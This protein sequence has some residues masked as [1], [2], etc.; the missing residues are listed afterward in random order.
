MVSYRTANNV[1][2]EIAI[3][4]IA[5]WASS[6]YSMSLNSCRRAPRCSGYS[7]QRACGTVCQPSPPNERRG[8]VSIFTST[9]ELPWRRQTQLQD[10][11]PDNEAFPLPH[12][13]CKR[14]LVISEHRSVLPTVTRLSIWQYGVLLRSTTRITGDV[15]ERARD[16]SKDQMHI[17][18]DA[19][20]SSSASLRLIDF[21]ESSLD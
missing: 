17:W 15:S 20:S 4:V 6:K 21:E 3:E 1:R 19:P 7:K 11:E 18:S 9:P 2:E 8:A 13:L 14:L 12:V 5:S 10:L 16:A